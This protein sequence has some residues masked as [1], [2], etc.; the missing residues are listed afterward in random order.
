MGKRRKRQ[1]VT[2]MAD[3]YD[4]RESPTGSFNIG[5]F[6][7]RQKPSSINVWLDFDGRDTVLYQGNQI[8][9]SGLKLTI[10]KAGLVVGRG[11][12][13]DIEILNDRVSRRHLRLSYD[14]TLER[15]TIPSI[16]VP[17]KL[18]MS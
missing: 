15:V 18:F 2:R 5:E 3:G 4:S 11:T 13:A 12:S 16:L 14:Q 6:V 10:D 9:R 17:F 1:G 8:G 7:A